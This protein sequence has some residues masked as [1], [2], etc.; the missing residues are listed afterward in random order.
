MA[1]KTDLEKGLNAKACLGRHFVAQWGPLQLYHSAASTTILGSADL[2]KLL[3]SRQFSAAPG[4]N[5]V[6]CRVMKN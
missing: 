5:G 4:G 2:Q 1:T 3:V 6:A